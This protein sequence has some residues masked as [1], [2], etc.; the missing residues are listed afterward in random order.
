MVDAII[1]FAGTTGL[2]YNFR[3]VSAKRQPTSA[4]ITPKETFFCFALDSA[5]ALKLWAEDL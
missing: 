3:E 2:S 1:F 4:K 5:V